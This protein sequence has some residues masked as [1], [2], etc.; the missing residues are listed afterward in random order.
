MFYGVSISSLLLSGTCG[1]CTRDALTVA[2]FNVFIHQTSDS[3]TYVI[4]DERYHVV[5]NRQGEVLVLF[6]ELVTRN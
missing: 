2:A 1:A 3:S 5:N 6:D 4:A